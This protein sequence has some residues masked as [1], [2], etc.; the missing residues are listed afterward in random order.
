VETGRNSQSDVTFLD[1]L[2]RWFIWARRNEYHC[3]LP[4]SVLN[5]TQVA[6]C[7]GGGLKDYLR[8][9]RNDINRRRQIVQIAAATFQKS[10]H[11][12][13]S[14]AFGGEKMWT[15]EKEQVFSLSDLAKPCPTGSSNVFCSLLS[16]LSDLSLD[17]GEERD[18]NDQGEK[19]EEHEEAWEDRGGSGG[20]TL[21]DL[22]EL[23]SD[24]PAHLLASPSDSSSFFPPPRTMDPTGRKESR[25]S[26]WELV[27]NVTA[28]L[29]PW[30]RPALFKQ[31]L[32]A[33]HEQTFRIT[34]V[35]VVLSASPAQAE[36]MSITHES[37]KTWNMTC[38]L[39][40]SDY[41][42]VYYM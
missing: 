34:Q 32:Q 11:L 23:P 18:V 27:F 22:S 8:R 36:L 20:E 3:M 15:E 31:Q 9:S 19:E 35:W 1:E 24:F 41:N 39:V 14:E 38:F 37:C 28:V 12:S 2:E 4:S 40:N 29:N 7:G 16:S 6:V 21:E 42:F 10:E 25:G 26:G 33:L 30:H 13:T 5:S 17:Q